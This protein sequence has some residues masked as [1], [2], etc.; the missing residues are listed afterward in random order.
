MFFIILISF[1]LNFT[2]ILNIDIFGLIHNNGVQIIQAIF[3]A[4]RSPVIPEPDF[5]FLIATRKELANP[6]KNIIYMNNNFSGFQNDKPF[7]NIIMVNIKNNSHELKIK[8]HQKEIIIQPNYHGK[9][10]IIGAY[11]ILNYEKE[12]ISNIE[13]SIQK[14]QKEKIYKKLNSGTSIWKE[15][16]QRKEVKK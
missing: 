1:I 16:S 11:G 7:Q 4:E 6:E 3:P 9:V 2:P 8:N 5:D 14:N 13:L 12:D 10:Y 15:K